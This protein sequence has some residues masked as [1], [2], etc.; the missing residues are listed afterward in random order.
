VKTKEEFKSAEGNGR[1]SKKDA[2]SEE[3]FSITR[4]PWVFQDL[5]EDM[6]EVFI[7]GYQVRCVVVCEGV[8]DLSA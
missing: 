4:A 1:P 7:K 5:H 8:Y 3:T 2:W 6:R